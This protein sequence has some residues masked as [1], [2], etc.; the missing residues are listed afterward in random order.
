MPTHKI[1]FEITTMDVRGPYLTTSR[2]NKYLL[3]FI[4]R[5]STYVEAF[6]IPDQT[7]ETCARMYATQIVTRHGTGSTLTTDQGPA[8][9]RNM[10]DIRNSPNSYFQLSPRI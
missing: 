1:T 8:F 9:P 6:P 10:Q 2:G 7:A 3:T 4:D 5:L